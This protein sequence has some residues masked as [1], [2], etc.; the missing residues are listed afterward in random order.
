M[1]R[2][3]NVSKQ[4]AVRPTSWGQPRLSV[5]LPAVPVWYNTGEQWKVLT[6]QCIFL[7]L[8][9]TSLY[10]NQQFIYWLSEMLTFILACVWSSVWTGCETGCFL[11]WCTDVELWLVRFTVDIVYT[12]LLSF[13]VKRFSLSILQ[14]APSLCLLAPQCCVSDNHLC[15]TLSKWFYGWNKIHDESDLSWMFV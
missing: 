1:L 10:L 9:C 15:G 5:V 4:A 3:W 7:T 8:W 14:S 11:L 12:C 13:K 6:S 2:K